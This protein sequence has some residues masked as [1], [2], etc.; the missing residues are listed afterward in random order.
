VGLETAT[1]IASLVE[2]NPDGTDQRTTAD[3][4]IRLVKATLKRSFPKVDGAISLSSV[5][6]GFIN[7]VS[8]SLQLQLNTLRDGSATA[9]NAIYANSASF[10]LKAGSVKAG[11][12]EVSYSHIAQLNQANTFIGGLIHTFSSPAL[13][14]ADVNG[15]L[16]RMIDSNAAADEQQWRIRNF[17]GS[18]QIGPEDD[19]GSLNAVAFLITRSGTSI[20]GMVLNADISVPATGALSLAN[21]S[22]RDAAILNTGTLDDA[23]VAFSNVQQHEASLSVRHAVSASFANTCTSASSAALLAGLVPESGGGVSNVVTRNVAGD[24]FVRYINQSATPGE[25]MSVGHIAAMTTSDGYWRVATVATV[26]SYLEARNITGRSGTAKN[27]ASG[28]GPPSLTGS[29]NGDMW[30]YY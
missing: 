20:A 8:K 27:L 13:V 29:T 21:I 22:I 25:S 14:I 16:L 7:D 1:Y 30:F 24:I 4:H 23:R 19:T 17:N 10:A 2:A 26:G 11:S 3:D 28:S 5:Q 18:F 6:F 15:P 9:N 12:L